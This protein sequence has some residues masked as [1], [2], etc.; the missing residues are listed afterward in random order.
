MSDEGHVDEDNFA[1]FVKCNFAPAQ[2]FA[3]AGGSQAFA[4]A[5]V[6][7]D[8]AW[9]AEAVGGLV[10]PSRGPKPACRNWWREWPRGPVAA[11]AEAGYAS[12]TEKRRP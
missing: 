4:W 7:R 3:W 8:E 5:G 9:S 10:W 1:I 2:A 12:Q 11:M 6:C